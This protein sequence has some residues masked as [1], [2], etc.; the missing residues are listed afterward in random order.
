VLQ[1]SDMTED[2][3]ERR[4]GEEKARDLKAIG[5]Y[6]AQLEEHQLRAFVLELALEPILYREGYSKETKAQRAELLDWAG[7]D[8]KKLEAG[9]RAERKAAQQDATRLL[10]WEAD[11][12]RKGVWFG[13]GGGRV[14]EVDVREKGYSIKTLKPGGAST[15]SWG[16]SS[17]TGT[18]A[19]AQA[20]CEEDAKRNAAPAPGKK[21]LTRWTAAPGEKVP[22]FVAD[23]TGLSKVKD[24]V[25]RYGEGATFEL[26]RPMPAPKGA[27]R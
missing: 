17:P 19:D 9:A 10:K 15:G 20:R 3:L 1:L 5:A 4:L 21:I 18:L 7:I 25:A 16:S 13:R 6:L 22:R 27:R 11:L 23:A 8:L 2:V 26:G 14:Y 24:I 12:H